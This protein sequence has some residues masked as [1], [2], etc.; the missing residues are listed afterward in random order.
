MLLPRLSLIEDEDEERAE[1]EDRVETED[2]GA[3]IEGY[4]SD[5]D[6][7]S[8]YTLVKKKEQ[9]PLLQ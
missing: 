8:E 9:Y 2:E 6:H 4:E 5:F 1:D 3:E 7:E